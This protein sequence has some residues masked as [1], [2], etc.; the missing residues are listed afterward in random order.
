MGYKFI[1]QIHIGKA[2][3]YGKWI[4]SQ[5]SELHNNPQQDL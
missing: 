4:S 1:L 5:Y 3:G 2:N